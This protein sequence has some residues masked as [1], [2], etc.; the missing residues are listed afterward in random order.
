[1]S[2]RAAAI[3]GISVVLAAR[4]LALVSRPFPGRYQ[5]LQRADD[6]Y[7][8]LFLLD[9]QTG[10]VW[11]GKPKANTVFDSERFEQPSWQGAPPVNR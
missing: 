11:Q 8:V 4:I 7:Q 1:M 5:L 10:K 3:V 6:K 9:T 2:T